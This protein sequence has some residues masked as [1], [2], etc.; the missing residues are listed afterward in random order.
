MASWREQLHANGLEE[1]GKGDI[2]NDVRITYIERGP[3]RYFSILEILILPPVSSS[4]LFT[5]E[6]PIFTLPLLPFRMVRF[7][8]SYLT[9][10]S[11]THRGQHFFSHS[12]GLLFV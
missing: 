2:E 1:L 4:L 11:K 8:R 10:P 7:A 3:P 6:S 5:D 12:D 9:I